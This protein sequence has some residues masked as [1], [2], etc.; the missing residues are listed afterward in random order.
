MKATERNLYTIFFRCWWTVLL[1]L[2]CYGFY[3]HAM[4]KKKLLH[5]ELKG[6]ADHLEA[7][8]CAAIEKREDLLMQMQS[9]S[10]PAWIELLIKKH[11]GMVPYGQTKVYFEQ[12]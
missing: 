4:H 1:I 11:L 10:D 6:K 2:F 8:L 5:D 3:L 9:Q 12:E 7:Q